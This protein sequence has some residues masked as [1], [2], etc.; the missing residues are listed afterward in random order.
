MDFVLGLPHTSKG[1]DT[2]WVIIDQL[3]KLVHFLPIKKTYPI[4]YL[5]KLYIEEIVRLHGVLVSIVS[6]RDPSFTSHFWEAL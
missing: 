6:N 5:A 3:M 4:H 1:H 2:I